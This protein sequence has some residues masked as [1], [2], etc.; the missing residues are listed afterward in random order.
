MSSHEM[1]RCPIIQI[2]CTNNPNILAP[3][4]IM[5]IFSGHVRGYQMQVCMPYIIMHNFTT[6]YNFIDRVCFDS[7]SHNRISNKN[8]STLVRRRSHL[9][10][11]DPFLYYFS[12]IAQIPRF[13][14][15]I[16]PS[17]LHFVFTTN[18]HFRVSQSHSL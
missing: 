15:F 4:N 5:F 14:F 17:F 13:K 3:S 12:F 11:Y 6:H 7:G 10:Q 1:H 9:F 2:K 16:I 18:L 8:T